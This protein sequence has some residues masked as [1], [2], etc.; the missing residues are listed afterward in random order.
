M[1]PV[2]GI[3]VARSAEW[4]CTRYFEKEVKDPVLRKKLRP[5][6]H[7]GDKRPLV[8]RGF[9]KVLQKPNVE[10]ITDPIALVDED[11]IISTPLGITQKGNWNCQIEE[12][13]QLITN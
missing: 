12:T 7:I 10:V 13:F 6:G 3:W 9:Y 4:Y 11:G 8:S 1:L 5:K 2:D